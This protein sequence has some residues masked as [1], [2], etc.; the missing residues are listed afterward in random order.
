MNSH[1]E[2]TTKIA[3]KNDQIE[4]LIKRVTVLHTL[5]NEFAAE[6][7]KLQ[8][9][10]VVLQD[11]CERLLEERQA[12]CESCRTYAATDTQ[13]CNTLAKLTADNKQLTDDINMMKMLIYRLNV[14]LERHQEMLRKKPRDIS[15]LPIRDTA[16]SSIRVDE[17][18]NWGGIETNALA[19]LLNAYQE[20]IN[21]KTELIWQHEVELNRLA[22]RYKDILVENEQ[23]HV[24]MDAMRRTSDTWTEQETRLQAQLDVCRHVFHSFSEF[25]TQSWMQLS[26]Y[27]QEQSRSAF[28]TCRFGERKVDGSVTLL[29]TKNSGAH[30]RHGAT[31]R[32]LLPATKR[33]NH[34]QNCAPTA[35]I[36]RRKAERMSKTARRHEITAFTRHIKIGDRTQRTKKCATQNRSRKTNKITG[37]SGPE[38]DHSNAEREHRVIIVQHFHTNSNS[39]IDCF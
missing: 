28:E 31:T 36:G 10:M 5:N 13:R 24:E 39:F 21:D 12:G 38:V 29:R 2:T 27:F 32:G 18:A 4:K 25:K 7:E 14:Q 16:T 33:S 34:M 8:K 26:I 15:E 19:P 23:L 3:E 20:T 11:K 9:E 35:R 22:G 1:P 6:H 37:N 17:A 30:H